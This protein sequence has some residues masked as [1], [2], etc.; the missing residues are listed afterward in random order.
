MP[1]YHADPDIGSIFQDG[2]IEIPGDLDPGE[3]S[4]LA[5]FM[6]RDRVVVEA[7]RQNE[8]PTE[9]ALRASIQAAIAVYTQR[10]ERLSVGWQ[11]FVVLQAGLLG[12]ELDSADVMEWAYRVCKHTPGW[13][14]D[15]DQDIDRDMPLREM[16][17]LIPAT[18][19]IHFGNGLPDTTPVINHQSGDSPMSEELTSQPPSS[20]GLSASGARTFADA[21]QARDLLRKVIEE[22]YPAESYR[23]LGEEFFAGFPGGWLL[24]HEGSY[25]LLRVPDVQETII[26]IRAGVAIEIPR[27]E[28]LAYY[29]ACENKQIM[30]GRAYMGYGDEFALI[31]LEE[32]VR[33]RAL[34]WDFEP[35]LEDMLTRFR[36]VI[37]QAGEMKSA[38]LERFGGRSFREE[39]G[40]HMIL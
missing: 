5:L 3:A 16:T 18:S 29:V 9:D 39:E 19:M 25:C 11:K 15:F 35:S 23:K 37:R 30:A 7:F 27:S 22:R 6:R 26:S 12:I 31:V 4:R 8:R 14:G 36:Y 40:I 1:N 38:V 13:L 17:Q 21:E 34:S 10:S 28:E 33:G 24:Q 32:I 2:R 20:D